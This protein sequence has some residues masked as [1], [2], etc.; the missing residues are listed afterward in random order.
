MTNLLHCKK[1]EKL[2]QI[3]KTNYK[4]KMARSFVTQLDC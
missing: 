4:Q 2:V 3:N 1:Q